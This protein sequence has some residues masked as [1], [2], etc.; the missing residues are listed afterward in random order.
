L[1]E[2]EA[3]SVK[4]QNEVL[5]D[6]TE[7]DSESESVSKEEL[8]NLRHKYISSIPKEFR[9]IELFISGTIPR[10]SLLPKDWDPN[11]DSVNEPNPSPTPFTTWQDAEGDQKEKM[12][13]SSES[14]EN[15]IPKNPEYSTIMYCPVSRKRATSLCPN[16]VAK[17]FLIGTEPKEICEYH[18]N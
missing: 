3:D 10:Q 6:A 18:V 14:S 13:E 2:A 8:E 17:T 4:A 11:A 7:E 9:R 12:I 1:S 5:D 16:K 15:E